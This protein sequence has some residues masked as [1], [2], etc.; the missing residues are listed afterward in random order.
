MGLFVGLSLSVLAGYG[1]ARLGSR[2][3]SAGLRRA[4]VATAC[5]L[6]LLESRSDTLTLQAIPSSPPEIYAD[7]TKDIGDSPTAA[8][9]EFPQASSMPT[10]MYY[11]TFHWQN[12][13]NGYSGFFPPSYIDL[14][15]RLESFPDADS[16][17]ALRRRGTRYVV[18][19]QQLMPP[20]RWERIVTGAER[21]PGLSLVATRTWR[22]KEIRLYRV[23]YP[24]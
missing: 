1:V 22:D 14:V 9:V 17:D 24:R 4:I 13:L 16:L 3:Q 10:Y 20:D 5:A 15:Y 21:T 8:I 19:H 11:S 23:V 12:L 18:V 6:I 2:I 7:L